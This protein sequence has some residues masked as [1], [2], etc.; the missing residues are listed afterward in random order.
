MD[1]TENTFIMR[2]R[3]KKSNLTGNSPDNIVLLDNGLLMRIDSMYVQPNE[4]ENSLQISGLI[5]KTDQPIFKYPCN[6]EVLKM[7]RV[8]KSQMIKTF[9]LQSIVLKMVSLKIGD[10]LGDDGSM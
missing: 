8:S 1:C 3:Y 4:T 5:I 2:L 10:G 6:S 9:P 7:W